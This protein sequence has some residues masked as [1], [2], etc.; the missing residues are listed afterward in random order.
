MQNQESNNIFK[1]KWVRQ[2]CVESGR[3]YSLVALKSEI[4]LIACEEKRVVCALK[5]A[6][7]IQ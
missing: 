1:N 7:K 2:T 4:P 6:I 3:R 5:D